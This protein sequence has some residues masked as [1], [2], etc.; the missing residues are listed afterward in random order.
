[1]EPTLHLSLPVRDLAQARDFYVGVL[2]CQPGRER[3][4]WADVWFF[5]MQV[6][7][8]HRPEEVLP[9]ELVGTRH[10][11]AT[12]DGAD[13]EA[14]LT[15]LSQHPVDWV[16]SPSVDHPGTPQE[17]RK[18]K[19]RDPSGNVIELKSYSNVSAALRAAT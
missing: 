5:G 7:L 15:S 9:P 14:L 19:L 3:D 16:R 8:Q 13:L 2:G 4:G 11:G 1:M 10:F 18:A 12:L 17:Q 6:T